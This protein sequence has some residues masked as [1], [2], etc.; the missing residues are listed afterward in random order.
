MT[1]LSSQHLIP[2]LSWIWTWSA[3]PEE[4]TTDGLALVAAAM[5]VHP[6][7][8]RAAVEGEPVED[9]EHQT[10]TAHIEAWEAGVQ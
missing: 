6:S 1:T 3:Q 9:H 5:G 2:L 10:I 8:L 4:G 7:L